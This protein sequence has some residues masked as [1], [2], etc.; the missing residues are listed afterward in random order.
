MTRR[1]L[2]SIVLFG[3]LLAA[4]GGSPDGPKDQA[5][6]QTVAPELAPEPTGPL[7]LPAGVPLKPTGKADPDAARV[8]R[9]WSGA[10]RAG[11]VAAATALWAI[12]AKVQNGTPVF[13]LPSRIHVRVFNASLPCGSV[14]T[15]AGGAPHGFT[16]TTFRLTQRKGGDCAASAGAVARCAIR[17]RDGKIV[18]WYRLP[19]DPDAP[20]AQP[21]DVESD[22]A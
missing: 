16:I 12:P 18:E 9:A 3:A 10:L 8:I 7:D 17:V 15:A 14:V 21:G 19:T 1:L 4:C 22:L 5:R 11:D 2:P 13:K 6:T 20:R